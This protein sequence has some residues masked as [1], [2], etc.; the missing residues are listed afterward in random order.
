MYSVRLK[1]CFTAVLT[2][3]PMLLTVCPLLSVCTCVFPERYF[4]KKN[5]KKICKQQISMLVCVTALHPSQQFFI[6]VGMLSGF[7][8]HLSRRLRGELL[9]YQ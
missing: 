8:A 9:V 3:F 7:L 2:F 5:I 4:E 1:N 6:H